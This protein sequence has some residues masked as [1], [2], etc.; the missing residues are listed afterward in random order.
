VV[1]G[2]D[3]T[4]LDA[5][6]RLQG[7][8]LP[9]MGLNIG[10]LGYLTC[11]GENEFHDALRS[12]AENSCTSDVRTTIS[13]HIID[14]TGALRKLPDALNEIVVGRGTSGRLAWFNLGINGEDVATIGS[15]GIVVATPT[16]ST[17]YALASGGPLLLPDT[18][19]LVITA[20]SPHALSFRPLVVPD[21]AAIT[22]SMAPQSTVTGVVTTDGC[23]GCELAAN[24]Q[25]ELKLSPHSV[26]L[27]HHAA[28]SPCTVMNR[29]LGWGGR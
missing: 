21:T 18:R 22:I 17:A 6:K 3:G 27:L 29:K 19:A 23:G 8:G 12:L 28:Y 14:A 9:L 24:E 13:A 5:V 25:L 26:T 20:I 10:S 2:G 11:V 16:G 7:S 15:D 1:L 4:V